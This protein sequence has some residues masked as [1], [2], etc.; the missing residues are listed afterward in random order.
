MKN[1]LHE[2]ITIFVFKYCE[3]YQIE[4][5]KTRFGSLNY[6]PMF[7]NKINSRCQIFHLD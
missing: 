1:V 5:L 6:Y 2:V 7:F 3:S 4:I